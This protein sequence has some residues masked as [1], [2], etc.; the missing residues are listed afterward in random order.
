MADSDVKRPSPWSLA[1]RDVEDGLRRWEFWTAMGVQGVKRAYRRSILGPLWLTISLA[2]LVTALSLLYGQLL[3]VPL[4]RYVPHV[5]LGFI[6]WQFIQ[7]AVNRGCNVFVGHKTWIVNDKWPLTLFVF[8]EVWENVLVMAHNAPVYAGTAILFGIAAGTRGLLIV[9]GLA[10]LFVNAVWVGL[11]LGVVCTRFRDVAQIVPSV[12]RVAFFVT[13]VIWFPDQ[14][15]RRSHLA[16][17]NPFACF[18]ELIRA[19]LIG[20]APSPAVWMAALAVTAAGWS[21]A[22]FVFVRYRNRVAYW[23]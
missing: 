1:V 6:A 8:K 2:V 13:P 14:L 21:V 3:D 7:S 11:L 12:M 17:Y 4:D 20:Q 9:P 15:G 18:V 22:W 19:P 16:M 23:L 10:L 5:A